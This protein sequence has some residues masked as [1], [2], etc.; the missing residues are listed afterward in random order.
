MTYFI[1]VYQIPNDGAR[2]RGEAL[3]S[4]TLSDQLLAIHGKNAL[5][6]FR[7]KLKAAA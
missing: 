5:Y 4:K 7:V 3:D 1:N 6:R 2:W